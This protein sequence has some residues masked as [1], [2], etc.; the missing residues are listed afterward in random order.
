[1]SNSDFD[2]SK[3]KP[4]ISLLDDP[5]EE[6]FQSVFEKFLHLGEPAL[7]ELNI[8][9]EQCSNSL[10]QTRL[11]LL[12]DEIEFQ[13]LFNSFQIWL[14]DTNID[15]IYGIWLFERIQYPGLDF[16]LFSEN[17][18]KVYRAIWI[19]LN[20]YLTPIEKIRIINRVLF[21]NLKYKTGQSKKL[22]GIDFSVNR[23]I[24]TK[25]GSQFSLALLYLALAQKLNIPVSGTLWSKHA[26]LC[27]KDTTLAKHAPSEETIQSVLFYI[28]PYN[29][30]AIYGKKFLQTQLSNSQGI[31]NEEL[32]LPVTNRIYFKNMLTTLSNVFKVSKFE[33]K[34]KKVARL[35]S[36]F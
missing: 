26:I 1:M 35:L 13:S 19:E 23:L 20:E 6:I 17:F 15:L 4:L 32:F 36:L 10:M 12:I 25:Q 8:A 3:I 34:Q 11:E 33:H 27:Y 22:S 18:E 7:G 29:N 9:W 14:S 2:S 5:S 24:Q 16:K 21:T 30:G 31:F 28:F